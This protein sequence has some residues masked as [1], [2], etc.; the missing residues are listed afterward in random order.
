MLIETLLGTAGG[1]L[2]E[3]CTGEIFKKLVTDKVDSRLNKTDLTK[4]LEAGIKAVDSWQKEQPVQEHLFY[5][6]EENPSK[7]LLQ[8]FFH[9]IL[10]VQELSKPLANQEVSQ[11]DCLVAA[12][13]EVVTSK[14]NLKVNTAAIE[15]WLKVFLDGY[16]KH[17]GTLIRFKVARES[18]LEALNRR[19][20]EIKFIGIL[21]ENLEK[22]KSANLQ[23][24]FVM[25]EVQESRQSINPVRE[26]TLLE[27]GKPQELLST[28][29]GG[30]KFP[31]E[32]LLDQTD[33]KKVVL[34]GAPGVGKSTLLR[35]F[36]L[37]L[38]QEETANLSLDIQGEWLPILI[39]IRDYERYQPEGILSFI[40]DYAAKNFSLTQLPPGFFE[41]YLEQGK[42]LI[43]IDGLDEAVNEAK[44]FEIVEQIDSFLSRFH[45]N[46]AIITSRPAGYKQAFFRTEEYPHYSLEKFD[47]KRVNLFIENWYNSRTNDPEEAQRC[48]AS[49]QKALS[50]RPRIKNLARN[51]LLLTIITLIHR[52]EAYL[53]RKRHKLYE[54][55][56]ETLL[57][58]WERGK[59]FEDEDWQL[60]YLHRDDLN[61]L[62]ERLAYWI[63]TQGSN[64]A[65]EGGTLI[66]KTELQ[67]QLSLY[68][69]EETDIKPHKAVAEAKRFINL[70]RDRVG[71]F[72]EQ[73]QDYYAFVHKTF[74][75]YLT[76]QDIKY[77]QLVEGSEVVFTHIHNHLHNPHWEEVLLVLISQQP[78]QLVT[79]ILQKILQQDTPYEQWLHRNLFFAGECL[80]ED[81]P[82]AA[83]LVEEI[84]QRLVELEVAEEDK[85]GRKIKQQVLKTFCS[86]YDTKFESQALALLK[87]ENIEEWRLQK[88]KV[89]LGEKEVVI[90][91]LLNVLR[92]KDSKVRSYAA[93]A[94]GELGKGNQ[95][96]LDALLNALQDEDSRLRRYAALTL[97]RLEEGNQQ[98]LDAL[99]NA[100]HDENSEVRK[101]ATS[102][103]GESGKGNQ[104]VIDALLNALRD[105]DFGV[106]GY[107][108]SALSEL[109]ERKSASFRYFA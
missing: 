85:V 68:I 77:R 19:C 101:N 15:P 13:Q 30:R 29:E 103:L 31:A 27:K 6:V 12:F 28:W 52:Y 105:E 82:V 100:L 5:R 98:V 35:Y 94:L 102:A 76:A 71:L 48:Q 91:E 36:T 14:P 67:Q 93:F 51:P 40:Q 90:V 47:A 24:I 73:G 66:A 53:P 11:L 17:T 88:Y 78:R 8:N 2:V 20:E 92:H 57:I 7:K 43:F 56:V 50:G 99:L 60:E 25:P 3:S 9:H 95:Q 69:A 70:I 21:G 42:A 104:E 49:L 81:L 26:L 37:I 38:S 33:G 80:A 59:G 72:N 86:L 75:E 46:R 61:R 108:A 89:A 22:E 62:M 84:L 18:Y 87:G 64:A 10:V 16:T 23:Q 83:G 4:A 107:A 74:Q 32:R 1:A 44:R 63:H 54:R 65:T 109:G 41:Y 97:G 39:T 58:N 55:A 45:H 34:L 96:V 79:P 106:R